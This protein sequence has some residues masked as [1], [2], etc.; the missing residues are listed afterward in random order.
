MSWFYSSLIE[1]MI[2]RIVGL[3][4]AFSI[5]NTLEWIYLRIEIQSIKE[6]LIVHENVFKLKTLSDKLGYISEPVSNRDQLIYLFQ[7]LGVE[8]NPFITSINSRPN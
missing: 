7:G 4:T 1:S 3:T 2:N 5:W 8:Y 6:G